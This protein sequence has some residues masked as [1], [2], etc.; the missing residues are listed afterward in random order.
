[1]AGGRGKGVEI[2]DAHVSRPGFAHVLESLRA[3][4]RIT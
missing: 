1:M 4:A 2:L 3:A